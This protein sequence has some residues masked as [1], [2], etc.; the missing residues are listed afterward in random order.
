MITTSPGA[1]AESVPRAASTAPV[2][3]RARATAGLIAERAES[4]V[5]ERQS[6]I[7]RPNAVS[8]PLMPN[9]A[10]SN[11]HSLSWMACGRVVGRDAVDRAVA[12]ALDAGGDVVRRAQRRVH[13]RV[14][15]VGEAAGRFAGADDRLVR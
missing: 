4:A 14:G 12:Q 9:A 5:F 13:L 3:V 11:S 10:S 2:E 8:R 6:G 7:A 15:V 1:P